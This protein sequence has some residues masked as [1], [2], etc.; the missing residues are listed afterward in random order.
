MIRVERLACPDILERKAS[1]WSARFVQ[2]YENGELKRPSSKQ[3]AHQEILACLAAMSHRKCFYCE[4]L[5]D[6]NEFTVDHYIEVAR[7][8]ERAFDWANLYL[9][10]SGCQHGCKETT[11][12]RA[13][14]LD[15]CDPDVDPA[16]HLCFEDEC[17]MPRNNSQKGRQTIG[18]Y[19]LDRGDLELRRARQLKRFH[20]LL[21]EIR[22]RQIREQRQ[23][24]G[25]TEKQRLLRFQQ[26]E[27]PYSLM[28]QDVFA[29]DRI[30]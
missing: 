25:E 2:R 19:R 13:E 1:E 10:C 3:Y 17:I 24:L 30:L 14:C 8:P 18:K 16:E 21:I 28:F 20:K 23:E 26:A 29:N 22:Q 11:I 9:C 7:D 5:L 12:S 27:H 15:P 6:E 4:T